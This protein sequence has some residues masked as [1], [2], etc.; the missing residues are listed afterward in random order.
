MRNL[1]EGLCPP[2][3]CQATFCQVVPLLDLDCATLQEADL[4]SSY[5]LSACSVLAN[6]FWILATIS[7]PSKLKFFMEC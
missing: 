7:G 3:F 5:F 1:Q 4:I 2:A 6:I